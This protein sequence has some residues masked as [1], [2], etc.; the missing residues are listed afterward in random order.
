M[1]NIFHTKKKYYAFKLIFS[2]APSNRKLVI[3]VGP[4]TDQPLRLFSP[5]FCPHFGL[6]SVHI[7]NSRSPKSFS[8]MPL[9]SIDYDLLQPQ[10]L[11]QF[12]YLFF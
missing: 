10:D 12:V 1:L 8:F 4:L 7:I 6:L 5:P 11:F 3:G 2:D 9:A